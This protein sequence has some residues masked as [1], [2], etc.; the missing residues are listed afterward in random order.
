MTAKLQARPAVGAL[1]RRLPD[2]PD[3]FSLF[4][5]LSEHGARPGAHYYE[6]V[7][8]PTIIVDRVAVRIETRGQTALLEAQSTGG[9]NV[10]AFAARRLAAFV[11]HSEPRRLALEFPAP[12]GDDSEARLL[13]P[14]PLDALR[15][16]TL[17][18]GADCDVASDIVCAGV[19]AYDFIDAF[20][21]LPAAKSDP[22]DYPDNLFLLAESYVRI[23][24]GAEPRA[25]S[26]AFGGADEASRER[27]HYDAREAL[28][29]LT[30][31]CAGAKLLPPEAAARQIV[32]PSDADLSDTAYAASVDALKERIRAGDVYQI[33]PSR[34]FRA[35]C[36]DPFA[37]FA[38]LRALNPSPIMFFMQAGDHTLFGATPEPAVLVR[39]EAGRFTVEVRP[40]AGTRP[41]GATPDEDDRLEADMR[42]D[43]KELAEHMMLVDLGRNDVARVCDPGTRRVV[44]LLNVERYSHVMH[45]VS[46]VTGR[47]R[48]GL[49][50]L[51]AAVACLNAGTLT[52]A[53][54]LRAMQIL[55]ETEATKRG[56]YGGSVGWIC[57]D[58]SLDTG[59]VIRSAYVKNGI[60][61]V[62]AGA[63]VVYDSDPVEEARETTR[64]AAGALAAI[65]DARG[66]NAR[67]GDG[68]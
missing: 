15:A 6:R 18:L 43:E 63:G 55:R 33:V 2:A 19:I 49:D 17:D 12:Q 24:P 8:A 4:A 47:L 26:M 66:R 32:E 11:T 52:G 13:A 22:L 61:T 20:E 42:L 31:R 57:G 65:A 40:I 54:K 68:L 51:H 28:A 67:A 3:G 44:R 5:H 16:V 9:E 35:P 34:S 45:L 46:Q 25:V 39:R 37:A 14:S 62:R 38:R 29:D 60:A 50:C 21:A 10:L 64:K 7:D 36:A 56:P 23:D 30:G 41:R 27:A 59:I 48:A 58:G 1:R 53:P